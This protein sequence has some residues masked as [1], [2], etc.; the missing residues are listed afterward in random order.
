MELI[1]EVGAI[2]LVVLSLMFISLG[3]KILRFDK[4]EYRRISARSAGLKSTL[5]GRNRVMHGRVPDST[6]QEGMAIDLRT[7]AIELNG[8]VSD[9][10]V[11]RILA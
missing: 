3:V 6:L 11:K 5:M 7:G 2:A 8:K 1:R 9:E 4:S 10:T